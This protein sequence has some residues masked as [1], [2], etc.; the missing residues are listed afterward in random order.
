MG[1]PREGETGIRGAVRFSVGLD[2]QM[3]GCVPSRF[4]W[5]ALGTR[6]LRDG[7]HFERPRASL[8]RIDYCY[9]GQ[10]VLASAEAGFPTAR[11]C[12][13]AEWIACRRSC[14]DPN[15]PLSCTSG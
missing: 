1:A 4:E 9:F 8:R 5:Q 6:T 11:C 14:G 2:S 15:V 12:F 7:P 3:W 10:C 13:G